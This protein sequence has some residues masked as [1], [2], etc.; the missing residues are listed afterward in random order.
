M[1]EIHYPSEGSIV[2]S[3]IIESKDLPSVI[4]AKED[5][6]TFFNNAGWMWPKEKRFLQ[7]IEETGEL[8]DEI[9]A[10][11]LPK[12]LEELWDLAFT[13]IGYI[14]DFKPI[15]GFTD[16]KE[17]IQYIKK[18]VEGLDTQNKKDVILTLV[19]ELSKENK[20]FRK[21]DWRKDN[22][23]YSSLDVEKSRYLNLYLINE[24][25]KT[26]KTSIKELVGNSIDKF[27]ERDLKKD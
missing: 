13:Y 18:R 25:T 12:E 20:I 21:T 6:K 5:V 8:S 23:K 1:K 16:K 27:T 14:E 2:E 9:L 3:P 26:Y 22:Y 24:L 4:Q 11:N 7:V 17:I 15:K 10:G 19:W